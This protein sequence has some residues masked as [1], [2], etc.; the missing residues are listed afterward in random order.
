M[1]ALGSDDLPLALQFAKRSVA[2][3]E[4]AI[5]AGGEGIVFLPI[6]LIRRSMIE[7]KAGRLRFVLLA[8]AVP[9]RT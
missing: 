8:R 1:I 7:L 3:D 9:A 6:F 5:K 2:I 4:A